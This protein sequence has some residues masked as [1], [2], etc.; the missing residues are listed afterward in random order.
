MV[1]AVDRVLVAPVI[2]H[3]LEQLFQLVSVAPQAQ[4]QRFLGTRPAP[5]P[6]MMA[7]SGFTLRLCVSK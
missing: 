5:V 1:E 7:A 3:A 6:G 4:E 2:T